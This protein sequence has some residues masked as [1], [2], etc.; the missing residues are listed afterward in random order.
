MRERVFAWRGN[1]SA[2]P[3]SVEEIGGALE[4]DAELRSLLARTRTIA[5][6]G[7]KDQ[8]GEDAWNVPRYLERAGYAVRA[9]NPKLARWGDAPGV[10]HARCAAERV[11]LI[12][13]FRAPRTCPRTSTRSSRCRGSPTRVVPARDPRRRVRGA[14]ASGRHRSR[15]G[16]LHH[17]RHET[18]VSPR[19]ASE[20]DSMSRDRIVYS[21]QHGRTCPHCGRP[22]KQCVCR[23][24][25]RSAPRDGDGIVRVKR[26]IAGRRGKPVTTIAGVPLGED[27]LH[28]LAGELKRRCGSGGTAQGRRDRDP[29]RPPRYRDRGARGARLHGQARGRLRRHYARTSQPPSTIRLWPVT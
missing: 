13:V 18:E 12:D 23:A 1:V 27:A 7:A 25:P 3:A 17:G 4:S 10:A 28:E 9:V 11:D 6:L 16:S 8:W 15:A 5:V 29:G 21:S 26:E 24:N 22:I 19:P 20:V 14:A 2:T